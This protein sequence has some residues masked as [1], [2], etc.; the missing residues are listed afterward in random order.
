[1][2]ADL[3]IDKHSLINFA[4]RDCSRLKKRLNG[5]GRKL[6]HSVEFTHRVSFGCFDTETLKKIWRNLE[7]AL[8]DKMRNISNVLECEAVCEEI[9]FV[10]PD[11][12]C[13][14]NPT[15]TWIVEISLYERP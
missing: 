10:R 7:H 15:M 3:Y 12:D 5:N 2:K 9:R 6:I 13:G 8:L 1:M 11:R 4:E 14:I